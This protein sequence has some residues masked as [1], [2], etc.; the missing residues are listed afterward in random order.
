MRLALWPGPLFRANSSTFSL[1]MSFSWL[2]CE[3]SATNRPPG[4]MWG[5]QESG[6]IIW[7][8]VPC[9]VSQISLIFGKCCLLQSYTPPMQHGMLNLRT[10]PYF[11]FRL[12]PWP[13]SLHHG[14]QEILTTSL[15]PASWPDNILAQ[16][17]YLRWLG[18][19][20][21]SSLRMEFFFVWDKV[22]SWLPY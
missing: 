22:S 9:N 2:M 17:L 4:W 5:C 21:D 7:E 11:I 6:T 13:R 8:L 16:E 15:I 14:P 19:Y 20:L 3:V 18:R 12:V 1:Q 10:M